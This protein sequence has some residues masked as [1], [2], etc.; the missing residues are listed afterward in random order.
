MGT[1]RQDRRPQIRP[2]ALIVD[3]IGVVRVLPDVPPHDPVFDNAAIP[4]PAEIQSR[5]MRLAPEDLA[6]HLVPCGL[7]CVNLALYTAAPP[8]ED[9]FVSQGSDMSEET[10]GHLDTVRHN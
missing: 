7:A 8:V 4:G 5:L 6:D 1:N 9:E 3:N 10:S 2:G